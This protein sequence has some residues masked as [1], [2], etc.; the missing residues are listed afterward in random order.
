M[1]QCPA[2]LKIILME[3]GI[4]QLVQIIAGHRGPRFIDMNL[5][6]TIP[7]GQST[8][9]FQIAIPTLQTLQQ[10]RAGQ[11]QQQQPSQL[12]LLLSLFGG[13]R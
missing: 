13:R 7:I 2:I 3:C 1:L 4:G 6:R 9:S 8:N 10:Q 12:A 5:T 11:Q